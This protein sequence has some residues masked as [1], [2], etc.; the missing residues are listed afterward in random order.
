MALIP[1]ASA[2]K[3][4]GSE[5]SFEKGEEKMRLKNGIADDG[6]NSLSFHLNFKVS[7]LVK[8]ICTRFFVLYFT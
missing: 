6:L 2:D 1:E 3:S 7:Y 4:E 5:E 8:I